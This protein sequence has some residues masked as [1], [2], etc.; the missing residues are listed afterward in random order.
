MFNKLN[1]FWYTVDALNNYPIIEHRESLTFED[2]RDVGINMN[3]ILHH[4]NILHIRIGVYFREVFRKILF[5]YESAG[6]RERDEN[7]ERKERELE[8]MKDLLGSGREFLI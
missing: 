2:L 7:G 6:R 8:K 1:E 4:L 3:E 5:K